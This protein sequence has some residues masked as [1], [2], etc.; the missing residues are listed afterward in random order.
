MK[1]DLRKVYKCD[2]CGKTM[3]SAGSM[4]RHEKYCR[5]APNN[6]HKC[7]D[8]C[9]NLKTSGYIAFQQREFTCAI[10]GQKLY[11]YKLEKM[12]LMWPYQTKFEGLVRMPL[13]CNHFQPM[14]WEEIE[15][16]NSKNEKQYYQEE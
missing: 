13:E 2:H 7:F 12:A 11:S 14:T 8:F 16:R 15:D 1:C 9:R 6:K 5:L 4:A 10:T 3:L